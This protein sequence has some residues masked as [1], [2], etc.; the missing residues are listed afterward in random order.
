MT[1][2]INIQLTAS[3][4]LAYLIFFA[5]FAY[6]TIHKDGSVLISTCTLAAGVITFKTGSTTYA[7]VK[8][9]EQNV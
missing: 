8:G 9:V 1:M 3:K 2:K 5:G 4:L 7:Q 6:A